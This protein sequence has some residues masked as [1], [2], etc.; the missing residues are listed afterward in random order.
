MRSRWRQT[1]A[2]P[3][4]LQGS[5][6]NAPLGSPRL[7]RPAPANREEEPVGRNSVPK[8]HT[9]NLFANTDLTFLQC[10]MLP[11]NS[12]EG[13]KKEGKSPNIRAYPL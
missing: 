11:T 6:A 2:T 1:L 12:G 3:E 5:P 4:P 8:K 9:R 10:E 7:T 13:P